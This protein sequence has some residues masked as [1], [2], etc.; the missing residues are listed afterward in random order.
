M[1]P[2]A[3]TVLPEV[4][5]LHAG[6]PTSRAGLPQSG[7]LLKR[8]GAL[9]RIGRRRVRVD[10]LGRTVVR[11]AGRSI[12]LLDGAISPRQMID[13]GGPTAVVVIP[14]TGIVPR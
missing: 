9:P 14:A 13:V 2:T 4:V 1:E 3:R 8:R 7:E 10:D 11:P 5:S 6:W 12:N